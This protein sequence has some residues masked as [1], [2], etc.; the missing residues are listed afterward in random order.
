MMLRRSRSVWSAFPAST[1]L[2]LIPTF[3]VFACGL[4]VLTKA[5]T[6][7]VIA[8]AGGSTFRLHLRPSVYYHRMSALR[9]SETVTMR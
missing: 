5:A 1:R 2:L 8:C 7:S 3:V 4:A 6:T 9:A